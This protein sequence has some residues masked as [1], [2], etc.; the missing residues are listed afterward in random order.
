MIV[1]YW[2]WNV[3]SSCVCNKWLRFAS[4][5][6]LHPAEANK[7]EMSHLDFVRTLVSEYITLDKG[8]R[9]WV[10]DDGRRDD[11]VL[12]LYLLYVA[13]SQYREQNI[14]YRYQELA[15]YVC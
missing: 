7:Q 14:Y 6:R 1:L 3:T 5:G 10:E 4:T 9:T 15:I 13:T 11:G 8:A 12:P 2:N